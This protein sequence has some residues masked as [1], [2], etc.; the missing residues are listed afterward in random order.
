M[1]VGTKGTIKSLTYTELT[2]PDLALNPPIILGNTYHLALDPGT[3]ILESVKGLHN[4]STWPNAML[5]DSGGFQ[6]VSLLKLAEINEQGVEFESPYPQ[7]NGRRIMLRPEESMRTQNCIGAD[8]MMQ[9]DDVV[10][11][12]AADD[13]RFEVATYRTLRWLDRCIES[14]KNKNEQNLFAIVQGGLDTKPGGLRDI[15]LEGFRRRD[16]DIPGYAIGGLA[17]GESK[18]DF[19]R[20]VAHSC[21]ALPQDKPRYLMGVGYPLDLVVCTALGVDMYDCVYPTRTARFGV[22]LVD[23][24][25]PGTLRLKGNEF[26]NDMRVIDDECG[27]QCCKGG[28][29]RSKL[30]TMLKAGEPVAAQLMTNHNIAYMLR[31]VRRMR[32]AVLDDK[33]EEFVREF[34]GRFYPEGYDPEYGGSGG[35]GVTE[36]GIVESKGVT[37]SG[38]EGSEAKKKGKQDEKQEKELFI[39]KWV[40]EALAAA[41]VDV[42]TTAGEK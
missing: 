2:D 17:G 16:H 37:N 22:A 25:A 12:V 38:D 10:S 6:M 24:V 33:Y 30:H 4:F 28:F 14:H 41:N 3:A 35:G 40:V 8:I 36:E 19:W 29:S 21:R 27:C 20:V 13:E 7:D 39:P 9:L 34:V 26:A 1:P 18:D 11:S 42:T 15:C 23:D 32:T 5:T 31:L